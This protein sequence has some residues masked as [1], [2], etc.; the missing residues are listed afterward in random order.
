MLECVDIG[1]HFSKAI[2]TRLVPF[3]PLLFFFY[4]DWELLPCIEPLPN[5]LEHLERDR[6]A[7]AL[8]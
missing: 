6:K 3:P 8:S 2:E 1:K 7:I 5:I 4:C